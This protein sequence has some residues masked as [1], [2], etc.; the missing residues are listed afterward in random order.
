[1]RFFAQLC[2]IW[3]ISTDLER[4]A[5][6]LRQLSFLF[7]ALSKAVT[8]RTVWQNSFCVFS[9]IVEQQ[10]S[11]HKFATLTYFWLCLCWGLCIFLCHLINAHTWSKSPVLTDV[12]DCLLAYPGSSS[13]Y[14]RKHG[15]LI[16]YT[17]HSVCNMSLM[18]VLRQCRMQTMARL[19]LCNVFSAHYC[20]HRIQRTSDTRPSCFVKPVLYPRGNQNSEHKC[21]WKVKIFLVTYN[22]LLLTKRDNATHPDKSNDVY[23]KVNASSSPNFYSAP[24]CSH[25]KRCTSYGNSVR[26]SVWLSLAGIVSK[27][28][29]V[30]RCSLHYQIPKCV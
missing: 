22:L 18:N 6:S 1:M 30:A 15:R 5:V 9:L 8:I 29:H 10:S 21:S 25:C 17:V 24:Q 27:R 4:L 14:C 7:I 26:L 12:T 28:L 11:A 13:E 16:I 2:S 3:H 23:E 19:S 20:V